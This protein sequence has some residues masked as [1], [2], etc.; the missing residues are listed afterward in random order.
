M[1]GIWA[2]AGGD[3]PRG[4]V[5]L[6]LPGR[7]GQVVVATND[8]ADP[9]VVIVDDDRQHI[10]RRAV[11]A[12]QHHVVEIAISSRDVA[13]HEVMHHGLT[14]QRHLDADHRL[15]PWRRLG[16]ISIAPAAIIELRGA[17][18]PGPLAHFRQLLRRCEAQIGIA[19]LEEL[20]RDRGVA[21]AVGEL[22]DG[23]TIP[24]EPEPLQ[25]IVDGLDGGLGRARPVRVFDTKQ[26]PAA[27][28]SAE[29]PVEEGGPRSADVQKARGRGGETSYD[30][31][32][33]GLAGSVIQ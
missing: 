3:Q 31:H 23:I 16:R 14:L 20:L 7:V 18:R 8:V 4:I 13:L 30:G 27:V 28:V 29:E 1:S 10:G 21:G 33:S 6:Q 15:G 32:L 2:N 5:N 12:Q 26:E 24:I 9:H 19:R 25:A 22:G 11:A 17:F